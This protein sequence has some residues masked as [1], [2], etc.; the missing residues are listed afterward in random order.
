[1]NREEKNNG[2]MDKGKGRGGES[3]EGRSKWKKEG[4]GM[5]RKSHRVV[6]KGGSE[7]G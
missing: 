2:R 5:G 1:M 6:F 7:K 3:G 4:L